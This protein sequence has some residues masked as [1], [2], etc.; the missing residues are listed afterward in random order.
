MRKLDVININAD[1]SRP[2]PV[3]PSACE[4]SG[5]AGPEPEPS[6]PIIIG[7]E[8][9]VGGEVIEEEAIAREMQ[10]HPAAS[11]DE[12]WLSAARAL[13]V[14]ELLWREANEPEGDPE[15]AI[16]ALLERAVQ[17]E[18][19]EEQELQRLYDADP[20]KFSAPELTE[21]AHILIEPEEDNK[22]GWQRAEQLAA[23]LIESIAG[24]QAGFAAA[25]RTHSGCASA[26]QDGSLGQVRFGELA[27]DIEAA[28]NALG[29]GEM[30]AV[31]LR[32]RHGYHIL[33][34]HHRIP[35]KQL[36]FEAVKSRIADMLEARSWTMSAAR[37]IGTLAEK[38]GVEGIDLTEASP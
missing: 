30:S 26:R 37:Y 14:R 29:K 33:K 8:V 27:P 24:E 36:P 4:T 5:C 9:R 22:G 11:A 6:E 13:A 28:L 21:A 19:P 35:G 10:H 15:E 31:P 32:S 34:V 16:Q 17:A 2:T 1:E 3:M 7:G 25:A 18:I 20:A 23:A 38:H 12:A